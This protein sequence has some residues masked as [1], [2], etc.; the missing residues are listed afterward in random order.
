M[1]GDQKAVEARLVRAIVERLLREDFSPQ[2]CW[3]AAKAF[4]NEKF[5]DRLAT[6]VR[7][8]ADEGEARRDSTASGRTPIPKG[9]KTIDVDDM[10]ALYKRKKIS[11]SELAFILD[12]STPGGQS[13]DEDLTAR[14]MITAF[15]KFSSESEKKAAW[16]RLSPGGA[17][18]P[19]LKGIL[20]R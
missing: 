12:S 8:V 20:N 16:S 4:Q 3:L 6:V 9:A 10:F 5:C 11:K 1:A 7:A 18:D 13:F 17:G 19:Y 15:L 14:E 2:D